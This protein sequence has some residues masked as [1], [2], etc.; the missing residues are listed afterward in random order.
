MSFILRKLKCVCSP[1][2]SVMQRLCRW[3]QTSVVCF[4]IRLLDVFSALGIIPWYYTVYCSTVLI[5][6]PLPL[7]SKSH[8][9]LGTFK[10]NHFHSALM[11]LYIYRT[12]SPSTLSHTATV[13]STWRGSDYSTQ[14]TL[15]WPRWWRGG[16]WSVCRLPPKQRL[17]WWRGWWQ[18]VYC[19][20]PPFIHVKC[21]PSP[22][23][24]FLSGD[25]H[26]YNVLS[27]ETISFVIK[28]SQFFTFWKGKETN[29]IYKTSH[30]QREIS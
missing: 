30:K 21:L 6:C 26:V 1:R 9:L 8:L 17:E 23:A 25:T 2:D 4:I 29:I 20:L 10:Q 22:R 11:M 7:L 27:D 18:W 5:K 14:T 15:R 13:G 16:P 19:Y 12:C 28:A 3:T 24:L